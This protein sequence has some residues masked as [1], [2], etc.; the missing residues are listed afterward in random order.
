MDGS[1][2]TG[3]S[4]ESQQTEQRPDQPSVDE[5]DGQTV[6]ET[7]GQT[8][9]Q[10]VEQ[11]EQSSEA[12]R[13]A[14]REVRMLEAM[15]F[16]ATEPVTE[17]SLA[18][19]LPEGTDMP[20]LLN[21]LAAQ[22]T[23]H[24]IELIQV[25]GKWAFRTAPDLAGAL[26]I[27]I[28]VTR[29]LSRAAVETLAIIAYHQPITRGEI[30]EIRGVALSKGTLDVLLEIGWIR[31]V[32]RRRTPGRPV[33]WGTSGNFL[34]HFN[35]NDLADLPGV[36]ELKAAGLLDTRPV[37][38]IFGE[39]AAVPPNGD[40]E[41]DTGDDDAVEAL[42]PDDSGDAGEAE[43]TGEA[44]TAETQEA[45]EASQE[46]TVAVLDAGQGDVAEQRSAP[47]ADF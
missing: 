32:G 2:E 26:N 4:V 14:S 30:E 42:D 16:A 44:A 12:S 47:P 7:D 37:R 17:A 21:E 41:G 34:D 8:G 38:T 9:E 25:A 43:D 3:D 18:Q 45:S 35:L 20:A 15:L 33:T 22:Y 28:N 40:D 39:V 5:T 27:E 23:G 29:K 10:V 36:D 6:D 11:A 46:D 19:R 13:E 31:P 1:A 24:G